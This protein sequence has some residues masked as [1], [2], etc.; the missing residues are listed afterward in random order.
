MI[1]LVTVYDCTGAALSGLTIPPNVKMAGYITGFGN[2]PWTDQQFAAHPD[3][4]RID[5]SPVNTPADETADVYDLENGAGTLDGLPSW[6]HAA[7]ASYTSGKRPGQ[8]KPT[9]YAARSSVT[10][11]VN[12]LLANGITHG[13]NLFIAAEA[14]AAEAAAEVSSASGP[15]PVVGRQYL[16]RTDYD[17]SV[18]SGPWLRDIA[19]P[20]PVVPPGPGT[21]AGWKFCR[22][23]M[24]LTW[25]A[26]QA[27]SACAAGGQHDVS[28]SHTYTLNFTV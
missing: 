19:H 28:Q 12:Q 26:Q 7:W 23:C 21:Q 11:V 8:R 3:A 9:V 10:P 1:D 18:V 24:C 25:A 2:V 27:V 20:A 4:I 13:V 17:V 14:D 16:F 15:F 5:Q 6:V 22:K